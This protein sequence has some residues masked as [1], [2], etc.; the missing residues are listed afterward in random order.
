MSGCV[1]TRIWPR[2]DGSVSDS[3]Y[4]TRDVVKT[5]S[6]EMLVLAPKD[7]PLKIGPSLEMLERL[8]G[9]VQKPTLMVNVALSWETGVALARGLVSIRRPV[10][11]VAVA[12][13]LACETV[14]Y[15]CL[16]AI[17]AP[18]GPDFKILEN[19]FDIVEGGLAVNFQG[20]FSLLKLSRDGL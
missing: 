4:P 13:H 5:A 8:C 12:S 7:R 9:H 15:G 10:V 16:K 20:R 11:S 2:Y 6:P 18:N 14:L 17:L 19:I 3:G 1:K